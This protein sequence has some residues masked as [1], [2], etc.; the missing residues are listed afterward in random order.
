M[1]LE[2]FQIDSDAMD[3]G[4]EVALDKLDGFVVRLRTL[5]CPQSRDLSRQQLKKGG[6]IMLGDIEGWEPGEL[7]ILEMVVNANLTGWGDL[8]RSDGNGGYETVKYSKG[9]ALEILSKM[10]NRP[11][12]DAIWDQL[13]NEENFRAGARAEA[14]KN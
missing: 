2:K 6:P 13:T 14:E 5:R 10:E 8:E 12:L 9:E 3:E 4:V 7:Q 11:I 1:R